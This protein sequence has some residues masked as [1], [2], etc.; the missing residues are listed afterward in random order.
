VG[1]QKLPKRDRYCCVLLRSLAPVFRDF[2][3]ENA[4]KFWIMVA[5]LGGFEE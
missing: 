2:D 1:K 3:S 4:K 5:N